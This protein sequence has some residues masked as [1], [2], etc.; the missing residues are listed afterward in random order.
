MKAMY[1]AW[2]ESDNV[3]AVDGGFKTQCTQ[4][5]ITFTE[6]ELRKYYLQEYG[7]DDD[8]TI[9]SLKCDYYHKE[10]PTLEALVADFYG[11]GMDPSYEVTK[12]GRGIGELLEDFLTY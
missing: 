3:I 11:S 2:K 5:T 7:R 6:D 12:N 10:F 4:Y 1:N 9:Y 8:A